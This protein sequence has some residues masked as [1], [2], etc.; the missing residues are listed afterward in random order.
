MP[1]RI[2]AKMDGKL[3]WLYY[4]TYEPA[5][6]EQELAKNNPMAYSLVKDA[7]Q[8]GAFY[9]RTGEPKKI[10]GYN[11][12][13]LVTHMRSNI[14][15][16]FTSPGKHID[17]TAYMYVFSNLPLPDLE[18]FLRNSKPASWRLASKEESERFEEYFG[19]QIT[20]IENTNPSAVI[21]MQK[22]VMARIDS[23]RPTST[24]A[25]NP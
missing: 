17:G 15:V 11:P 5:V 22:Y 16:R 12:Y 21:G 20:Y 2:N 23:P 13:V 24:V 8:I 25:S 7:E 9:T 18:K 6:F 10:K 3:Y 14:G 1:S 19:G 4:S